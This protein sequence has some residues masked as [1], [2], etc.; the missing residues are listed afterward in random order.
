MKNLQKYIILISFLLVSCDPRL[1][2]DL[3]VNNNTSE[4]IKVYSNNWS[5]DLD[6]IITDSLDGDVY[7]SFIIQANSQKRISHI[8]GMGMVSEMDNCLEY[9]YEQELW[10][11]STDFRISKDLNDPD[12]WEMTIVEEFN[13]GGGGIIE[14]YFDIAENDIIK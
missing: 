13:H 3:Y 2:H 1:V 5:D 7:F 11:D 12:N 9:H 8:D 10:F 14:C 6:S 4:L